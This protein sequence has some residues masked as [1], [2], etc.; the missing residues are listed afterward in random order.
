[1]HIAR[2]AGDDLTQPWE[3]WTGA[4]WSPLEAASASVLAGVA[5][6]YSVTP[7][8]DGYL[9]VTPRHDPAVQAPRSSD[10]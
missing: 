4:G 9:L 1:M 2:V 7:F 3:Y 6:E 10:T 8:E 5:N